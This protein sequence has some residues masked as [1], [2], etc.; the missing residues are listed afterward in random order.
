ME[1]ERR[2]LLAKI[3]QYRRQPSLLG[4]SPRLLPLLEQMERC[5][6][7]CTPLVIA[8]DGRAASGK[9]T[10]A[11]QL[12]AEFGAGVVHVDDFFLPTELRTP[13]RLAQPG[14]NVHYE[15][16][17]QQ[18]LPHLHS[19]E[20]FFYTKFD[21]KT[22]KYSGEEWVRG[23]IIRVVEGAYSCH[24][25]FGDYADITVFSDV[26][27]VEQNRRIQ[28]RNGLEMAKI[29][30]QKWIPMEEQYFSHTKLFGKTDVSV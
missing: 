10:L 1:T 8:I 13:Q 3:A 29:F 12:A 25:V 23:G 27:P 2:Q 16:F 20:G 15:R 6:P 17:T 22:M 19:V 7:S 24:P 18:V 28:L 21:C 11:R 26:D 4:E 9:T 5:L 30:Q 14:G